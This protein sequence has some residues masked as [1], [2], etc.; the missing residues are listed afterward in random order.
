[1]RSGVALVAAR[2][3]REARAAGR[4]DGS[5]V[6]ALVERLARACDPQLGVLDG[7]GG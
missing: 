5:V 2:A 3:V 6:D 7:G 1:M 4:A